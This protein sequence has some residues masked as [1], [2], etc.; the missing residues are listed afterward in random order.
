MIG[1][2]IYLSTPFEDNVSYIKNASENG[3]KYVFTS[4]HIPEESHHNVLENV[5][6]LAQLIDDS[7]MELFVDIS[8]NTLA[9]YNVDKSEFPAF[10]E[11]LNI[12]CVRIDYGF[13]IEEIVALQKQFKIVLN[14][15]VVTEQYAI[16]CR[17][18]GL[19]LDDIVVCHNYYPRKDTGLAPQQFL[20]K[21]VML[22]SFGFKVLAF[23]AGDKVYR[24]PIREGL[25][26]LEQHRNVT[27]LFGYLS[28]VHDFAVDVVVLGD[29]AMSE[30]AWR[31]IGQYEKEQVIRIRAYSYA[32]FEKYFDMVH[33]NRK[34]AAQNVVRSVM[35]RIN[36]VGQIEPINTIER[37][38]GAITVDNSGYLRY[39]G[40]MQVVLT[41]LQADHRVN[42][43]GY[44][45]PEDLPLISY[46]G[47]NVSFYLEKVGEWNENDYASL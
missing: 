3:A 32:N 13:T 26:T 42:V 19:K 18:A 15:S 33:R 8:P 31:A 38:R 30:H 25:P 6:K 43:I 39:M 23:I 37:H 7:G 40:E 12:H 20:Q 44:V 46:L 41:H 36:H 45:D 21:N 9:L 29:I 4:L 27:P 35:S 14:A 16:D 24:G 2:S 10:L 11:K 47:S 28:L 5:T 34:D 1:I 17:E 22:K